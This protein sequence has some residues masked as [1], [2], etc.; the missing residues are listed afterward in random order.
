MKKV[1]TVVVIVMVSI[2]ISGSGFAD[3]KIQLTSPKNG[4]VVGPMPL[5]K[6][7]AVPDAREYTLEVSENE[8]FG[9]KFLNKSEIEG[10][11]WGTEKEWASVEVNLVGGKTYYWRVGSNVQDSI[12]QP[13]SFIVGYA[14]TV[15]VK[16]E[17]GEPL[18]GAGISLRGNDPGGISVSTTNAD[19]EAVVYGF[20]DCELTITEQSYPPFKEDVSLNGDEEKNFKLTND[21]TLK[22]MLEDEEGKTIT[23]AHIVL[24]SDEDGESTHDFPSNSESISVPQGTYSFVV[25]ADGF[26]D[27]EGNVQINAGEEVSLSLILTISRYQV[28]VEV[29]DTGGKKIKYAE[30]FLGNTFVGITDEDG[31]LTIPEVI[32]GSHRLVVIKDGYKDG[33]EQQ[34]I[35]PSDGT[36]EIKLEPIKEEEPKPTGIIL[37]FISIILTLFLLVLYFKMNST[38]KRMNSRFD[39]MIKSQETSLKENN[40]DINT[41]KEYIANILE[42]T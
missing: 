37:G 21:G 33:Y 40:K 31:R 8:E 3:N 12:S 2:L 30:V 29:E 28:T 16:D 6:W 9:E 18:E 1:L 26:E 41:M 27:E 7:K 35:K 13:W 11:S 22:V 14:L 24:T 17:E 32:P 19:G 42:K 20:G 23:N 39:K 10:T 4:H 34:E 36:I 15:S 38:L 5:F 25:K